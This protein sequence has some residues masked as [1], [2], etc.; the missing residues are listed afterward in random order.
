V[1]YI[2]KQSPQLV[3]EPHHLSIAAAASGA[4]EVSSLFCR[5]RSD[6]IP[7]ALRTVFAAAAASSAAGIGSPRQRERKSSRRI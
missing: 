2:N 1:R 3:H 7:A 6:S 5:F 4:P